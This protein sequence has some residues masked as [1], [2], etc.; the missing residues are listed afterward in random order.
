[1]PVDWALPVALSPHRLDLFIKKE[2]PGM[3]SIW[4]IYSVALS[5]VYSALNVSRNVPVLGNQFNADLSKIRCT[6]IAHKCGVLL[7]TTATA[8]AE[9]Y[10]LLL[11]VMVL[12]HQLL[13]RPC[14][15]IPRIDI[16]QQ[17][18]ARCQWALQHAKML[19]TGQ[20][21][22]ARAVATAAG[23]TEETV[24]EVSGGAVDA[25][26][27]AGGT[28]ATSTAEERTLIA[29][30]SLFRSSAAPLVEALRRLQHLMYP[31]ETEARLQS[32]VLYYVRRLCCHRDAEVRAAALDLI[33][34]LS[35]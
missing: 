31:P 28:V 9:E 23:A 8:G 5:L 16:Y 22:S 13:I 32:V 17:V 18:L 19:D 15:G 11:W 20:L 29:T 7:D 3:Y 10:R 14:H 24:G 26:L 34:T 33:G 35:L 4:N 21:P 1:M 25:L 27:V 2:V 6:P 12:N 30:I